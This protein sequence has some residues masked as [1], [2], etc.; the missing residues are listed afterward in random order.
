MLQYFAEFVF[1]GGECNPSPSSTSLALSHTRTLGILGYYPCMGGYWSSVA[2]DHG[3]GLWV[4]HTVVQTS[5]GLPTA[6]RIPG[7]EG[8]E[9]LSLWH[10]FS[11]LLSP[12]RSSKM[13]GKTCCSSPES[14]C[15]DKSPMAIQLCQLPYTALKPVPWGSCL[16]CY[17]W[18]AGRCN[19]FYCHIWY[20]YAKCQGEHQTNQYQCIIVGADLLSAPGVCTWCM[21]RKSQVEGNGNWWI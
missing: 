16:A 12:S 17:A 15:T 4:W 20:V 8:V 2:W 14:D 13:K 19:C 21:T 7:Q 6:L 5:V 9:L 11:Y 10:C 1:Y 18:N 3:G